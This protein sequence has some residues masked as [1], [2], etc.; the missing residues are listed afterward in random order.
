MQQFKCHY[1]GAPICAVK[2][3]YFTDPYGERMFSGIGNFFF[4]DRKSEPVYPDALSA[5]RHLRDSATSGRPF[6]GA[7]YDGRTDTVYY[8]HQK[9]L[10]V[11][12]VALMRL[13]IIDPPVNRVWVKSW[14][15]VPC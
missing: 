4:S 9:E 6:A 7:V 8:Q 1:V 14:D 3:F 15:E 13:Y 5:A 11:L 2:V 12:V 10:G